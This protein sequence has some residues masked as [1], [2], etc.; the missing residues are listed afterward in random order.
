M[1][2]PGS[3]SSDEFARLRRQRER[4]LA[5]IE[6]ASGAG[7]GAIPL[8]F[9]RARLL[10][11]L[12]RPDA[13]RD[14][15]L[16]VLR[17][18]STDAETLNAL[19]RLLDRTGF[20]SAARTVYAR[21][22]ETNP[23]D[24]ISHGNLAT[25]LLDAGETAAAR[26]HYEIAIRLDP[27][28]VAARQ[29]LAILLLRDGDERGA[30][31]HARV[32]F[33]HGA[34]IWAFRG[35]GRPIPVLVVHSALGGNVPIDRFID[36]RTFVKSTIV[37]EF[38]DSAWVLPRHALVVNAIGDASRC[39]RALEAA[40]DIV[41]ATAAPV[42]NAPSRIAATAREALAGAL[43]GITGAVAPLTLRFGRETLARLDAA[44]ELA[45][46]GFAWPLIVRTPGFQTGLHCRLVEGPEALPGALEMLPGD[47]LLAIAYVDVRARKDARVRKFRVM[48]VDGVLYPLHLAI[49]KHWMVHYYTADTALEHAAE[50]AAFLDDMEGV[51]GATALAA[52][53]EIAMRL[54]LDYGGIDFAFDGQG[55]LVV[56]EANATMIVPPSTAERRPERRKA[57]ERIEQAM[58]RMLLTRG[59]LE[60]NAS[61]V[62]KHKPKLS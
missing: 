28:N 33:R 1:K 44:G 24:A 20:G 14:A 29:C 35:A 53:S 23:G 6:A 27:D 10:D 31:A 9:E 19:G 34:S 3:D 12:G 36:D 18:D 32:G 7:L 30:A 54:G 21:A 39:C 11:E 22:V 5:E 25:T 8:A 57:V 42:I 51:L 49:S 62:T 38:F 61:E 56:F 55:R 48:M 60:N 46:A 15:Y 13:A 43:S 16:D 37:A 26:R 40:R 58:R 59:R 47:E 4:R 50:E 2:T 41:A 52:L 17:R 45:A